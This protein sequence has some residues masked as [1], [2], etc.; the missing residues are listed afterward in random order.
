ML[1]MD[2]YTYWKEGVAEGI[3]QGTK[4]RFE[5]GFEQGFTEGIIR[6]KTE[7]TLQMLRKKLS[8]EFIAEITALT[9]EEITTIGKNTNCFKHSGANL[10]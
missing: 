2:H 4:Q 7:I 8:L 3:Q 6:A 9:M 1:S 5:Q 10:P